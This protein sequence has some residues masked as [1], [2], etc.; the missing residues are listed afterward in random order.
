MGKRLQDP[1]LSLP[2]LETSLYSFTRPQVSTTEAQLEDLLAGI[3]FPQ[4]NDTQM[5]ML[6]A[7]LTLDEVTT[8]IASFA[9]SKASG[10]GGSPIEFYAQY[11]EILTPK[12]LSLYNHLF[13]SFTLPP[14]MSEAVIILIPKLGKDPGLPESYKPISLLQVDIKILAK[15]LALRLN[16]VILTLIHADQAG[17]MPGHNTSFSPRKLYINLQATHTNVGSRVVVALDKA[18]DSVE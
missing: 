5:A 18:F 2:N 16:Q 4:L 13:D 1:E 12:L 8:A 17:F 14:S 9:R 10:S 7:P 3:A 15:V 6:D 11:S